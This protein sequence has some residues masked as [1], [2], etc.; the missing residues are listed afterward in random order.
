MSKANI[1]IASVQVPFTSGGVEVLVEGLKRELL[2]RDFNVDIVRLPFSALPK[3]SILEQILMWRRLDLRSFN[4]Q[5]VDLVIATKFPSYVVNHPCKVTWLVHQHRQAYELYGTRFGDFEQDPRDESLRRMIVD[6]DL[7][8]LKECRALYTISPTVK[9][10]LEKYLGLEATAITPPLPQGSAYRS[11]APEPFILSVGR[12]CSIK[13]VDLMVKAMALVDGRLKLKVVGLAD[14][15]SIEAY[16]R[17]EVDKHHLWDRV[18]FLGRV[19]TETL[20]DLYSRAFAVYYAPHDEDYGFVTIEALASFRPVITATDSG[21]VLEFIEHEKNGLV[22]SPH[23]Q[24]VAQAV[25]RLFTDNALYQRLAIGARESAQEAVMMNS[26]DTVVEKLTSVL[27][28]EY[29]PEETKQFAPVVHDG[30]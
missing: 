19:D 24:A 27:S 18:E 1:L 9:K 8:G 17:S 30:I 16:L 4:G 12:I 28:C 22:V 23:E 7:R 21:G 10:R 26:W 25:N 13:R 14:E 29:N 5:K 3:E 11:K 15:P 6:A 20:L 2:C